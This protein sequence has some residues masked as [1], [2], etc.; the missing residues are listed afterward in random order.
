MQTAALIAFDVYVFDDTPSRPTFTVESPVPMPSSQP[1]DDGCPHK[2]SAAVTRTGMT[3]FGQGKRRV[4]R[5]GGLVRRGS[6]K[7]SIVG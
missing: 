5:G 1:S 4:T 7:W 6:G 3:A 2:A